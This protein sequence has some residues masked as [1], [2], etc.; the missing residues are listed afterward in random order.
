MEDNGESWRD[1]EPKGNESMALGEPWERR[2]DESDKAWQ[3][4]QMFRD[5]EN[6]SLTLDGR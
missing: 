2:P 5:S 6:R 3:A 1:P 4:F